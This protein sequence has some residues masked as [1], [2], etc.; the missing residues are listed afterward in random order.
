M[1]G[2][3]EDVPDS[4]AVLQL[5]LRAAEERQQGGPQCYTCAPEVLCSGAALG[6]W[7]V[8]PAAAPSNCW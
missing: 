4:A 2:P 3:Q 6:S 8:D 1:D 5:A 7:Q